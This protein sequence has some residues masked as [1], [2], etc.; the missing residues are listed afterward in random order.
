LAAVSGVLA[1]AG[2]CDRR[3]ASRI[4]ISSLSVGCVAKEE[5][6]FGPVIA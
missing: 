4:S 3:P 1:S 6:T 5:S 2:G